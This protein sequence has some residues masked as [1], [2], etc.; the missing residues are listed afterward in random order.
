MGSGD[1]AFAHQV[2]D[3]V[4]NHP[5]LAAPGTCQYQEG[6]I[7]MENSFALLGI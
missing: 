5:C 3:L 1:A 4:G 2:G 7:K 6:A